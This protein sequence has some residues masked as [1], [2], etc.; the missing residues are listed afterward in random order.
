MKAL[1]RTKKMVAGGALVLAGFGAGA[2]VAVTGSASAA[3]DAVSSRVSQAATQL[4]PTKSVRP[5]EH[6]LTGTT[7]AKVRA[8]ALAK[9]PDA[10]IQRVETDSDGVYEAHIVTSGGQELIVQVGK[11]FA[12]TG[13]DTM[14]GPGGHDGGPQG[15]P[16]TTQ[17][18][19]GA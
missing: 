2:A 1:S 16:P 17:E 5:D 10:T 13:T 19:S 4:D 11:D 15:A 7:A 6:L 12:V 18:G 14:G 9:Y 8:A 3:T